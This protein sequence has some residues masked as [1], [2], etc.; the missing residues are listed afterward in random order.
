MSRGPEQALVPRRHTN[1]Q[2]IY[3]KC[4]TSLATR[5]IQIKTTMRYHLIPVRMAVINK[6]GKNKCGRGC[7]EKGT[8]LICCWW[9]Y[10]QAQPLWKTVWRVLKTST[11]ELPHDP[12]SLFWVPTG[13]FGNIHWQR[14]THPYGH[15]SIIHSA[16]DLE[17]AKVSFDG[18]L[19]EED[20]AHTYCTA[21]H[22]SAIRKD[23]MPPFGTTLRD[24]E[25]LMLSKVSQSLKAKNHVISLL[26]GIWNWKQEM[27]KQH[28]QKLIDTDN[29]M[30]V[31]RGKGE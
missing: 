2:Q 18:G 16:W 29:S 1:G 19:D 20:V 31:T 22:C 21:E 13:K 25:N 23:E 30:V 10:K 27:N 7:A 6:T 12:E 26:C 15:F 9:R 24:L 8:L 4:S 17:T 28:K 11:M 14:H 3:E 5:E